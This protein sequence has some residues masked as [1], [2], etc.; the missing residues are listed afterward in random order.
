MF[1]VCWGVIGAEPLLANIMHERV[2]QE[3]E[4]F[5]SGSVTMDKEFFAKTFLWPKGIARGNSQSSDSRLDVDVFSSFE[6]LDELYNDFEARLLSLSSSEIMDI[7]YQTFGK[8]EDRKLVG[9]DRAPTSWEVKSLYLTSGDYPYLYRINFPNA[10]TA[11][12]DYLTN[13]GL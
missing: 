1:Q 11:N 7:M 6:K 10:V 2:K 13:I 4:K 9:D 8:I 12:K 5:G 3:T